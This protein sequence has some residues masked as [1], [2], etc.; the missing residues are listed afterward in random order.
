MK[1]QHC[2]IH[3]ALLL[4]SACGSAA[5]EGPRASGTRWT[6]SP[7]P[8]TSIGVADGDARYQLFD[9]AGATRLSDGRIV[10]LNTGSA[11]L[12]AYDAGGRF[13][14][15]AGRKGQGPGE[16]EAPTWLARTAGDTIAVWDQRLKRLSFF[17]AGGAFDTSIN[18]S[19]EGMFPKAVGLFHDRSI[20]ID[21][22]PNIMAMMQGGP[23]V[24]RDSVTLHRFARDGSHGGPLAT[25]AGNEVHVADRPSGFSWN[26]PPF[27]RQSFVT[28]AGGRLYV[29]DG[30]SGEIA[31]YSAAGTRLEVVR[32]P[33]A[34]WR[35]RPEDVARY[36]EAQLAPIEDPERRREM[37]TTL[38]E[39]PVPEQ[40]PALGAL[41]V[42]P[43]QNLWAQAYPRPSAD[44]VDWG[45]LAPDGTTRATVA[46]PRRLKVLEVGRDYVLALSRDEDG[47][48]RVEMYSLQRET[49][50]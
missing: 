18:T 43:D 32:G 30:G 7:E 25:F 9:V 44:A 4:S 38:E 3:A 5:A 50:R 41:L 14:Y 8:V 6:L 21:P 28:V 20:A 37:Q 13:L 24:R 17:T 27:A 22:G 19:P 42:D 49:A 26:D 31:V 40:A 12:S 45:I 11:S 48:E 34:P 23:G 10:V 2:L 47:V 15:S 33:H 36:K 46:V 35:I 1:P 39:A 29:A 16:F